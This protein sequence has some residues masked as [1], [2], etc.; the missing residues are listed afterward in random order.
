MTQP[1]L[2]GEIPARHRG[3]MNK[4]RHLAA[5]ELEAGLGRV[6]AAPKSAGTLELIV[7]RPS[8]GAREVLAEGEL[9]LA[10]GLV[11]DN[12]R[13]R[14]SRST[15][16]GAPHPEMQLTVMSV[17]LIQ[18]LAPDAACWP[19]A[20]DQ[21][22]VDLDLSTENLP[23]GTRLALGDAIIEVTAPPHTGCAKFVERFGVEAMTFVNSPLGKQLR[24]RGLNAKVVQPGR[25]RT[26]D[27]VEKLIPIMAV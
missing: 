21:L 19:L 6:R 24:L 3:R 27:R 25:I 12:W 5:R 14:G 8:I 11:G 7:R 9:D 23:P 17:R 22:Y 18:L 26:G 4:V 10:V 13:A 15:P 2:A 16:D 20:G 1:G